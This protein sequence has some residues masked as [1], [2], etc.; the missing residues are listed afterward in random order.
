MLP[1]PYEY[2]TTGIHSYSVETIPPMPQ[3]RCGQATG[4]YIAHIYTTVLNTVGYAASGAQNPLRIFV[5]NLLSANGWQNNEIRELLQFTV[6]YI[7]LLYLKGEVKSIPAV[8]EGLVKAAVTMYTSSV[9]FAFPELKAVS[10]PNQLNAASQNLGQFTE[11]KKEI[12]KMYTGQPYPGHAV[13]Q[14]QPQYQQPHPVHMHQPGAVPM[15][16]PGQPTYPHPGQPTYPHPGH[17]PQYGHVHHPVQHHHHQASFHQPQMQQR[18]TPGWGSPEL[19]TSRQDTGVIFDRWSTPLPQHQTTSNQQDTQTPSSNNQNVSLNQRQFYEVSEFNFDQELVNPTEV[20]K[21]DVKVK[22]TGSEY[23]VIEDIVVDRKKHEVLYFGQ[24]YKLETTERNNA[25]DAFVQEVAYPSSDEMKT[26]SEEL[27]LDSKMFISQTDLDC[28][29]TSGRVSQLTR[30]V[31]TPMYRVFAYIFTPVVS[32]DDIGD[33]FKQIKSSSSHV[34]IA[35]KIQSIGK[36]L[37]QLKEKDPVYAHR[38][39]TSLCAI[40][41]HLTSLVNDYL[42]YGLNLIAQIT[43]FSEDIPNI[44]N[45]VRMN[46]GNTKASALTS[47][48]KSLTKSFTYNHS[49][50]S[51]ETMSSFYLDED[52]K[53]FINLIPDTVSITYIDMT[54]RELGY[55][56]V[57]KNIKQITKESSTSLWNIAKSLTQHKLEQ[58]ID[59]VKDILVTSDDVKYMIIRDDNESDS[60][61]LFKL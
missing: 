4:A 13:P 22:T 60:F 24:A 16:H 39:I 53:L 50:E 5:H 58:E 43:S 41:N 12:N 42:R 59:T 33:Y 56:L 14:H 9:L 30:E 2:L 35:N 54:D 10:T 25:F 37:Q 7:E 40:D 26:K 52:D 15:G 29:I 23:Q 48:L 49:D 61:K 3:V 57:K 8:I 27:V 20:V 51:L 28:A 34:D 18:S 45:H 38:V 46:S 1:F 44:E 55:E 21:Q 31:T 47:Y 36:A 19:E 17:I 6:D 11:L 32:K